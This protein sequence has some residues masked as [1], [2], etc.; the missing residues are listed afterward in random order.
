MAER[1]RPR[2]VARRL[3]VSRNQVY[4]R[5]QRYL[6]GGV[7]ALLTDASRPGLPGTAAR[8]E[9]RRDRAGD[10]DDH[11]AGRHALEQSTDGARAGRQRRHGP[12]DLAAA[13]AATASP[14][15]IQVLEAIP[16]SWKSCAMSSACICI[17]LTKRWSS[18]SMPNSNIQALIA[19][20]RCRL[21][22]PGLPERQ[23]HDYHRHGTTT[24]FAALRVLD[25][26]V[27]GGMPRPPTRAR[28]SRAVPAAPRPRYG[29]DAR[30]GIDPGQRQRPQERRNEAL[31]GASSAGPCALHAHQQPP[32]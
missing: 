2:H 18:A 6:A 1:Q 24:L 22:Q 19:R 9:G 29:S 26:V 8:A 16:G 23:T 21:L 12:Q 10:A 11:A 5:M 32:G 13:S 30:S 7:S 20:G 14:G 4:L 28:N 27:I 3:A 31:V 17:R 15:T 25:G